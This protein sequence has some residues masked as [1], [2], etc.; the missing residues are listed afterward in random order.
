M[1]T[2][3]LEEDG[4]AIRCLL[5][6]RVSHNPHDIRERYCGQCHMFHD[7]AGLLLGIFAKR[8]QDLVH[9]I[10]ATR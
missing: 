7:D 3:Q 5:C 9:Q 8:T 4:Q 6:Q 10:M 1:F 2:Y